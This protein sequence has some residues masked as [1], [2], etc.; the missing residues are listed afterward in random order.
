VAL[1]F[2]AGNGC[3]GALKVEEIGGGK[4]S[5]LNNIETMV[6]SSRKIKHFSEVDVATLVVARSRG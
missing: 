1:R 6:R 2:K 4:I 3:R 5:T